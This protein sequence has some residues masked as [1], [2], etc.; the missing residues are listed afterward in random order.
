MFMER[1]S[2]STSSGNHKDSPHPEEPAR[3][4]DLSGA[5][6]SRSRAGVSK[7][8]G[9]SWNSSPAAILRDARKG[10]LLR[11][12]SEFVETLMVRRPRSG[13]LEPRDAPKWA[14]LRMRT[15]VVVR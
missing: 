5:T 7:D 15:V 14:L 10:A 4:T 11:M 12:R 6:R 1:T 13:R 2:L 3:A 9:G 8:E